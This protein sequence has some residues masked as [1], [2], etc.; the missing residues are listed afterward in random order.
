[1]FPEP[2]ELL[3]I[4]C[5]I[6]S[7]WTSKSK[8]NTLTPK[9][10]SQTYW[11]REISHVMD[12]IISCVCSTLAISVQSIVVKWCRKEHKKNEVKKESQPSQDQRWI[13]SRDAVKGLQLRYLPLHQ[14]APR[15]PYMK[16]NYLWARGMSSIWERTRL[17]NDACSSRYPQKSEIVSLDAGLRMDG[18]PALD[19]WDVV[20][21]ILHSSNH[22]KSSTQET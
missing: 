12:G 5:L 9:T 19:L 8:S 14:K 10:N 2:T 18:I 4:S 1:M 22:K 20:I 7:I 17:V 11:P 6:E 16:V 13:W 21:E 3:L 15:K